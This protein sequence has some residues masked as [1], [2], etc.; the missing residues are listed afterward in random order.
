MEAGL[1]IML[2][3]R[4]FLLGACPAEAHTIGGGVRLLLGAF[5]PLALFA[6]VFP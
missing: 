1:T 3:F 6:R 5:A 4:N 2:E